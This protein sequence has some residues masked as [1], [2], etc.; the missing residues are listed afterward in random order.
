MTIITKAR[1][2]ARRQLAATLIALGCAAAIGACG[3]TGASGNHAASGY[4]QELTFSE[5]MRGHGVPSYPDPIAGGGWNLRGSGISQSS[6][7]YQDAWGTCRTR[8][9]RGGPP[10]GPSEQQKQQLV[11]I[12]E[13]MRHHG[14]SGFPDP[15]TG[16]P[17]SN[18]QDYSIFDGIGVGANAVW[19]AVPTTI[20]ANSPAF[21]QAASA[22]KLH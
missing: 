5:C 22:C 6:P 15:V 11:A 14:V 10:P 2:G 17:P 20:D 12:S 7:A 9:P 1:G 19:L 16:T 21:K 18:T 13:C 8:L 4:A 3:S